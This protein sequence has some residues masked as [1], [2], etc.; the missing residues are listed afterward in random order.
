MVKY[1][2]N[3]GKENIGINAG[4]NNYNSSGLKEAM[5]EGDSGGV[6]ELQK[7]Q[8]GKAF[9]GEVTDII[10]SKVTIRLDNGQSI[11]ATMQEPMNF[12]IGDKVIFQIKSN[13]ASLV[14]IKPL[15]NAVT[16]QNPAILKALEAAN[17]PVNEKVLAMMQKLLEEQMPIDKK[18]LQAVYKQILSNPDTNVDT[19]VQMNKLKIWVTQANI[20]QFEAYK[21]YEHRIAAEVDRLAVQ[22]PELL[23]QASHENLSAADKMHKQLLHLFVSEGE[24]TRSA[25]LMPNQSIQGKE[26]SIDRGTVL[27]YSSDKSGSIDN[28]PLL[29]KKVIA[30]NLDVMLQE[31]TAGF[32]KQDPERPLTGEKQIIG[33]NPPVPGQ[34]GYELNDSEREALL[35]QLRELPLSEETKQQIRTGSMGVN[36]F[37]KELQEKMD[38]GGSILELYQGNEYKK[39]LKVRIVDQWLVRPEE[40]LQEQKMEEFYAKLRFQSAEAETIIRQSGREDSAAARTLGGIKDNIEFMNQINQLFT[41][42]QLP[43]KMSGQNAHSDLYIFTNKK[44]LQEKE[45]S[46]SALLHLDMEAMGS[47]DIYVELSGRDVSV[48]FQLEDDIS[49]NMI[50]DHIRELSDRIEARGYHVTTEVSYACNKVD[51]VEDFLE[52]EHSSKTMQRYSFDVR[53]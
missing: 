52:R 46:L 20:R 51:F 45:G 3:I 49:V 14:E 8:A 50:R 24:S 16:E 18:S 37:L 33:S 44:R 27:T 38:M 30:G 32:L 39:L 47:M 12:N 25:D 35:T 4:Y 19:I 40:L 23:D 53:A 48:N 34:I 11:Q 36:D 29:L 7:L 1:S 10:N 43:L 22:L 9:R 41:Y 13:E 5:P 17:I 15:M 6:G 31:E 28:I 21:N 26:N 42:I 2:N